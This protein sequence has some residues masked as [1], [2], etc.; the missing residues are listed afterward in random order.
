MN[1]SSFL[2]AGRLI[3]Y[4]E[5]TDSSLSRIPTL[6]ILSKNLLRLARIHLWPLILV[7]LI[8]KVTS[9]KVPLSSSEIISFGREGYGTNTPM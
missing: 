3:S 1:S 8:T 2:N 4:T 9:E 6:N 5:T 7:S